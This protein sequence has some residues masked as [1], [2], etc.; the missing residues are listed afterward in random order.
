MKSQDVLK[1]MFNL[2]LSELQVKLILK[3]KRLEGIRASGLTILKEQELLLEIPKISEKI[4]TECFP[5]H[6][7][8]FTKL[9]LIKKF[10]FPRFVYKIAFPVEIV[11]TSI[12]KEYILRV[13]YL[14]ENNSQCVEHVGVE[15]FVLL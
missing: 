2:R 4:I 13:H 10:L 9:I 5:E 12:Y 8:T 6:I 7:K 14:S 11:K 3:R 15:D 1:N